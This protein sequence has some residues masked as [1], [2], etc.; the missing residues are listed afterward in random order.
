M[1]RRLQGGAELLAFLDQLL[2]A[3]TDSA[4]RDDI[5]THGETGFFQGFDA[6]GQDRIVHAVDEINALVLDAGD[7]LGRTLVTIGLTE[8]LIDIADDGEIGTGDRFV[9]SIDRQ[10][11]ATIGVRVG[12]GRSR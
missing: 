6:A 11:V 4:D 7:Q 2:V 5:L 9:E 3:I 8:S 12:K 1:Q 10:A